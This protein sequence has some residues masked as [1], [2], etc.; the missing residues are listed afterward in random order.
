MKQ[1]YFVL[2]LAHSLHG[3]LRRVH[4][5]HQA[6]YVILAFALVGAVTVFGLAGSYARMAWKTANY[7]A[8]RDQISLLRNNIQ[9]L[10]QENTE[11]NAQLASLQMMASEVTVAFGLTRKLAGSTDIAGEG[12][13][14]PTF[15]ES[16]E[17]YNFLKSASF[18]KSAPAYARNFHKNIIPTVWPVNGQ[19][20]SRFGQRDDP[21][22]GEGNIHWGVDITAP[23][24]TPVHAAADGIVAMAEWYSGYGRVV[25]I[26]HGNGMRTWYGHLSRFSVVPGQE[27]RRSE[28][29]G[30]SGIS[31]R[32]TGPHL[33]FEVR[34]GNAPVN[35]YTYLKRAS[36]F[37]AANSDLP[38]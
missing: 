17:E 12:P 19:I 2:V 20:I 18:S 1:P 24:N 21:F 29:L 10:Q 6:L 30:Y 11:K 3:R 34:V 25:I 16:L 38:F 14:L 36:S 33:H 15:R 23:M 28:I 32:A 26:D 27:I 37:Q 31:G 8:L 5:P 13:L 22:S 7:N 35:P 4:I 9:A